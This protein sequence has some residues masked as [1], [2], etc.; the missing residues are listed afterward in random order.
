[1]PPDP[2]PSDP[3]ASGPFRGLR[4]C[5][6]IPWFGP[7][8]SYI[9]ND[10]PPALRARGMDVRIITSEFQPEFFVAD[11]DARFAPRF[12]PNRF[13]P[14]EYLHGGIDVQRLSSAALHRWVLLRGLHRAVKGFRPDIVEASGIS[15]PLTWQSAR[16]AK[17]LA[18]P[19]VV[20]HH[21][22]RVARSSAGLLERAQ[23]IIGRRVLAATAGVFC[24]S[25]E[26]REHALERYGRLPA[27]TW[28]MPLGVD[29]AAF[30]PGN[31]TAWE[32]N[33]LAVRQR[34]GIAAD[35]PLVVYSGR[36]EETKGISLLADAMRRLEGTDIRFAF[37]GQGTCEGMLRSC[38][39]AHLLGYLPTAGL[40]DLYRA[41]DVA[42]WPDSMSVSQLHVL[43]CG[44][45]L[46]VPA[47][48]PKPELI[49]CGAETFPR[50]DV[51]AMVAAV[52]R[53]ATR[54]PVTWE[55]AMASGRIAAERCSWDAIANRRIACYRSILAGHGSA[56]SAAGRVP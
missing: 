16:V 27:S 13:P 34:L 22:P 56:L 20:S 18:V 15:A 29:T 7:Q 37:A 51:E 19:F 35:A 41:C 52:R 24:V 5:W 49:E 46:L 2:V 12:G 4:L 23:T 8:H 33:R 14:G 36:L 53:L 40:I 54:R 32:A 21:M 47:P 42:V 43:A 45:P 48:H 50:G 38:P 26:A 9:E 25:A 55:A 39:N 30:S 6:V 17:R 11:W 1:M 3:P 31:R 44:S 10:L 28:Q